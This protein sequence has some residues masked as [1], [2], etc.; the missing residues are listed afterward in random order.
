MSK[1]IQIFTQVFL[2]KELKVVSDSNRK[3]SNLK[4]LG[5]SCI[6]MVSDRTSSARYRLTS[7]LR[8]RSPLWT[9][10]WLAAIALFFPPGLLGP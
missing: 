7:G 8:S 10:L 4:P 2:L 6:V 3:E 5:F 1:Y 9:V